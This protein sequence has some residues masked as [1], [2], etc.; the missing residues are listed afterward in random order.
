MTAPGVMRWRSLLAPWALVLATLV[1]PA[2]VAGD[3]DARPAGLFG[4]LE[5]ASNELI[6]LPQWRDALSRIAEERKR[7]VECDAN[8]D[9]CSS[10]AMTAWRSMVAELAVLS[11][12]QRLIEANR[13]VN[14]LP[15]QRPSGAFDPLE[16]W[17][18]PLEVLRDGGDP[19]DLA[20]MKFVTLRDAGVPNEAMRIVI[21]YDALQNQRHAVLAVSLSNATYILDTASDVVRPAEQV[22]YYVPYYSVNETTRWAYVVRQP[23]P[24]D[25]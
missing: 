25:G 13:Y 23:Q 21:V 1:A 8:V 16:R 18:S 11:P 7:V 19:K 4:Y 14:G 9:R 3:G 6:A 5:F 10:A 20:V 17:A 2:A 22:R 15:G 24:G 12:R